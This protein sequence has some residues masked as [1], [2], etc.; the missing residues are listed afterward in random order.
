MFSPHQRLLL[1]SPHLPDNDGGWRTGA[2]LALLKPVHPARHI[3][4][5]DCQHHRVHQV[6]GCLDQGHGGVEAGDDQLPRHLVDVGL[7]LAGDV[8]LVAV[9]GDPTQVGQ[10]VRLGA[11]SWTSVCNLLGEAVQLLTCLTENIVYF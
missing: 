9:E 1:W 10:E 6:L 5:L 7:D 8:E 11:R 2:G 3:A 4:R